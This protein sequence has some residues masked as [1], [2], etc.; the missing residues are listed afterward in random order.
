MSQK[1]YKIYKLFVRNILLLM[2]LVNDASGM[3]TTYEKITL[4][5]DLIFEFKN[6]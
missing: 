4:I 1:N 2:M 5:K 3:Q 6:V